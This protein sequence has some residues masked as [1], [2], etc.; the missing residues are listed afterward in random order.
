MWT[1]QGRANSTCAI[2]FLLY[3]TIPHGIK[4]SIVFPHVVMTAASKDVKRW[5]YIMING[6]SGGE[7]IEDISVSATVSGLVG[8]DMLPR[9]A[10]H[11]I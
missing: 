1:S 3:T 5:H 11:L 4:C 10:P 7:A 2:F 9:M 6:D 8:A